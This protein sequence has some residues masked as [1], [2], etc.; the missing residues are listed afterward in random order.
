MKRTAF[1]VFRGG[2]DGMPTSGD[3]SHVY[4][5][6]G[7]INADSGLEGLAAPVRASFS[8][9][10]STPIVSN[11][12]EYD[13]SVIR[14]TANGLGPALPLWIPQIQTGQSDP[15]Q[16]I[17]KI[18]V[19]APVG[20]TPPIKATKTLRWV[21]PFNSRTLAPT[22]QPPVDVQDLSSVYYFAQT[23]QQFVDIFN[24]ALYEGL[25]DVGLGNLIPKCYL[26]YN[27]VTHLFE[28][29]LDDTFGPQITSTPTG[30]STA[31]ATAYLQLNPPL[32]NLLLSFNSIY[33]QPPSLP[34]GYD[35][36]PTYYT[37]VPPQTGAGPTAPSTGTGIRFVEDYPSTQTGLWSPIDAL[38]FTSSFL[39]LAPEQGT[40]PT[41]VGTSNLGN[42]GFQTGAGFTPIITDIAFQGAPENA[43]TSTLYTPLAE[44][45]ISSLT[46]AGPVQ[47][48][49]INVFFRYR[50][51]GQ[52]I[53]VFMPNNSSI[54]MKIMFR[55]KSWGG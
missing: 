41:I 40:V 24:T 33:G 46:S 36:T 42:S 25:V 51:T 23:Y 1:D 9:S 12:S 7:I 14:F 48:V 43:L 53:P 44:Y 26:Y 29:N 32:N 54:T 27:S 5:N 31:L 55:K 37:V 19:H 30:Y 6:L 45:R 38:C 49:D 4:V 8:E 2:A 16:T 15:D 11:T 50:L 10:R 13:L 34:V 22:P 28:L 35:L 18:V 17:Y 47:T 3:P 20:G 39:P 52:L 21:C